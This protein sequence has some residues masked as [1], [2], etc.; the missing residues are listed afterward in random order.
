M[1]GK[2]FGVGVG[3]GDPDLITVKGCNAI[4]SSHVIAYHQ[5]SKQSSNAFRIAGKW[6]RDDQMLLPLTY[7]VTT[8]LSSY[9][10]TYANLIQEFYEQTAQRLK[11]YLDTGKTICVLA[12]GDP[13]FYSS[14]MYIF[15]RLKGDY[16][17]E[18]IPGVSSIFAAAAALK[19]PLCYRN[20]KFIVLSAVLSE[21]ELEESLNATDAFAIIKLGRN[22]AKVKRILAKLT[23]HSH[24]RYIE[25]A[26]MP[27]EKIIPLENVNEHCSPYFSMILIPGKSWV[28]GK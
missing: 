26:S 4:Q 6:I 22:I 2:I 10:Q 7:P 5:T 9:S 21:Q 19:V 25:R 20:Q 28:A 13:L 27:N 1:Q 18:I 3:P 8:E 16:E 17:I 24:A 15:D 11:Q 12:E 23:L 14:F